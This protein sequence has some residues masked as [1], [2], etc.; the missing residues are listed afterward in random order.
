MKRILAI[1]LTVILVLSSFTFAFAASN[2]KTTNS[3]GDMTNGKTVF[4]SNKDVFIYGNNLDPGDYYIR[5]TSP[6]KSDEWVTSE[7]LVKVTEDGSIENQPVNLYELLPYGDTSNPGGE[8]KVWISQESN[9]KNNNSYTQ[10]FKVNSQT[11]ENYTLTINYV[12]QELNTMAPTHTETLE[13]GSTYSVDSPI[14]ADYTPDKET[15]EGTITEDTTVTVT[16]TTVDD[17]TTEPA[18]TYTLTLN[19]SPLD[20]GNVTGAGDYEASQTVTVTATTNAGFTFKDWTE[21]TNT[22][23]SDNNNLSFTFTMPAEDVELTANF[24]ADDSGD[25]TTTEP[26]VTYTVTLNASPTEGG[27]VSGA[28]EYEAGDSVTVTAT[29]NAGFTFKDWKEDT[30]TGIADNNNLSFT[31]TMPEEDV[32][33]TANFEADNSGDNTTTEQA[34]TYTVTLN[35]SPSGVGTVTGDGTY[36]E[37]DSVTINAVATGDYTFTGWNL[38]GDI[39]ST[40]ETY[41][42]TMPAQDVTYTAIFEEKE[43]DS[44]GGDKPNPPTT[45]PTS[46][47]KLKIVKTAVDKEVYV[48]E[49]AKFI[50]VVTNTGNTDLEDVNIKDEMAGIDITIDLD[51]GESKILEA[52]VTT[53]EVGK[54]TN[55]ASAHGGGA[56]NTQDSA[57]VKVV[58]LEIEDDDNPLGDPDTEKDPK[59]EPEKE[60]EVLIETKE[61]DIPKD[62]PDT[63]ELEEGQPPLDLPDTGVLPV[64]LF[65]GLGALVSGAGLLVSKKK[66]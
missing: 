51:E 6:G 61:E 64:E 33:L 50:I 4:E 63:E 26:A 19:A 18:V 34:V 45:G 55:I 3:G 66:H 22:G 38:N 47:P 36:E 40:E 42:F 17:T 37:N 30:N 7:A 62:T 21:D 11:P 32:E 16:Y 57:S 5:I 14:I 29:T 28:E 12:D 25:D 41:N 23:I 65:Y 53:T 24:E 15:V 54:L 44:G 9:F 27:T 2:F 56:S 58:A 43:G 49:E 48:G 46:N 1:I 60:E 52:S 20:G 8:Y 10:N 35:T 59:D 31:F 13:D 39:A